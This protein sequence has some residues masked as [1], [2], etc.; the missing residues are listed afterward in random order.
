MAD[1]LPMNIMK[2]SVSTSE[3]LSALSDGQLDGKEFAAALHA[4]GH[5]RS[6][7]ACWDTYHLI[8]DVLRLPA[9]A[10]A[11]KAISAELEFVSRFNKRLSQELRQDNGSVVQQAAVM[12]SEPPVVGLIDRHGSAS[13]DNSFRWKVVAGVASLAA[14]SAIVWNASVLQ[15]PAFLPQLAELASPQ[16]VMTS[17]QGPMV[18]DARLQ[19]LLAAHKQFGA[20]SALQESSGFLRNA[21]FEM[22][23]DAASASGR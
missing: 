2:P 11:P 15:A 17:A 10:S 14:V 18:R 4:C 7:L 12:P 19:E 6:A 21:T 16:I 13:N 22:P 23:Q 9:H 8:G 20:A 5:D 1:P 3:L